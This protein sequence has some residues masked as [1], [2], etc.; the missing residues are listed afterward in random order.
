[1]T[2]VIQDRLDLFHG[3]RVCDVIRIALN[4][5]Q[6]SLYNPPPNPAKFTDS[7]ITG[8]VAKHGYSSW[9]LDALQPQV[10]DDLLRGT[11]SDYIDFEKWDEIIAREKTEKESLSRAARVWTSVETHV[12]SLYKDG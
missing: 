9:E 8:Y 11:I 4:E 6:I 3:G 2:R 12:K 10:I 1:M 5:D 7:R